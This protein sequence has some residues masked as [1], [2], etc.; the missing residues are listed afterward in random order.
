MNNTV[1]NVGNLNATKTKTKNPNCVKYKELNFNLQQLTKLKE[2]P[3]F[4][5]ERTKQ[6]LAVG[7]YNLSNF[8]TCDCNINQV[9]KRAT[10][11]PV[12]T[13]KDGYGISECNINNDSSLR[14]GKTKKFPKCP[15]QLFERPIITVPYMGRGS[16]N[17]QVEHQ[18]QQGEQTREK[19]ECNVLSGVTIENYFT[20]LIGVVEDNIQKPSNLI[21]EV[22]DKKWIRGGIPSR[23]IVKDIDYLERCSDS[24]NN[25]STIINQKGYLHR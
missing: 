18:I 21:Q 15:D 23:Q 24:L 19:R 16:G 7:N 8:N 5:K 2:D 25:K 11:N 22:N 10:D 6:S 20:P 3:C 1:C 14:V 4:L 9:I 17:S 12:I 13:F